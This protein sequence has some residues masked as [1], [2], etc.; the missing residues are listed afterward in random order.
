MFSRC[1]HEVD[2][3][4]GLYLFIACWF[5]SGAGAPLPVVLGRARR[6][7]AH[8]RARPSKTGK[9]TGSENQQGFNP[10]FVNPPL[11]LGNSEKTG[12]SGL[13]LL[14]KNKGLLS[15]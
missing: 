14:E 7:L 15:D 8:V 3:V 9:P 12:L 2:G 5:L 1:L 6:E 13:H 10:V 11:C 4:S